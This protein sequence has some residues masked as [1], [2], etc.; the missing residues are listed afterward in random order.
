VGT[1]PDA[2]LTP[3]AAKGLAADGLAPTLARPRPVTLHDV[4]TAGR[5][6]SFGCDLTPWLRGGERLERWDVPAVGD[7][8]AAARDAIVA[9]LERLVGEMVAR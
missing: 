7:G 3:A 5:I 4:A 9:R 2:E 6:V 1:E 8:Y